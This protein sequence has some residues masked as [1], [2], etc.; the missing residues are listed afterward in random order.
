M[1]TY[2]GANFDT[3]ADIT[4][5]DGTYLSTHSVSGYFSLDTALG[6]NLALTDVT[7]LPGFEFYFTDGRKEVTDSSPLLSINDFRIATDGDGNIRDWIIEVGFGAINVIGE[8]TALIQ[9]SKFSDQG[10]IQQVI[11]ELGGKTNPSFERGTIRY[12]SPPATIGHFRKFLPSPNP[13]P[14]P[15]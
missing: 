4:P 2:E 9:T 5:P 3:I 13:P 6:D 1:Y 11:N 15:C 10:S 7:G 14:L 8:Q 12:G